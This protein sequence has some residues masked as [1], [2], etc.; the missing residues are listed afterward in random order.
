MNTQLSSLS[1]ISKFLAGKLQQIHSIVL[2]P[3]FN[4]CPKHE[5]E[6]IIFTTSNFNF[7]ILLNINKLCEKIK[8]FTINSSVSESSESFP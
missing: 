2:W 6:I 8:N 1:S 3:M 7:S 4:S 5:I